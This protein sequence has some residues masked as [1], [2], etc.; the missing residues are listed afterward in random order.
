MR[1]AVEPGLAGRMLDLARV[2]QPH[3]VREVIQVC[4]IPAPTFHEEQRARY[5]AERF[6]AFGVAE[7]HLDPIWN[8]TARIRGRGVG[9][10]LLIPAHLDTVFPLETD[11]RVKSE[12]EILRA[13]GVGD[14]SAAVAVLLH[15]ARLLVAEGI[16]PAGDVVLAATVGEEGLGNLRG[17]RAVLDGP[18]ADAE[19]VLPLDGSLGGLVAQG[20]GSR[21]WRLSVTA[22]GGHSWG[23]FGAPSA[24]HALGRMIGAIAEIRVPSSPKTTYNVG[25][26]RGGTSVNTIAAEAEA[27]IDLRS[28]SGEELRRL[29]E[30]MK[31]T[32]AQVAADTGTFAKWELIGDRPSGSIPEEHPLCQ[33]VRTVHQHLNIP[34]RTYASSTDGNVP[35][36]REIPAVTIGVTLGGN[37]HRLDEYI[38]TAPLVKGLAQVLLLIQ[39]AAHLPRR[40]HLI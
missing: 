4:Q 10:T 39:C 40:S 22:E 35:L 34:T 2:A 6:R 19:Y 28:L 24:I 26:I 31:R 29:E 37:G 27:L 12:G 8:V 13:P 36:A 14:N 7:V 1:H 38:H 20:V 5:V 32:V 9:P 25:L 3:V 30:R 16:E 33:L 23:A 11:V 21:R 15:V 18:A 17:I